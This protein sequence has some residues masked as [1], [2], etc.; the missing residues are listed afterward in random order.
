MVLGLKAPTAFLTSRHL[1]IHLVLCSIPLS[2][3]KCEQYIPLFFLAE[4]GTVLFVLTLLKSKTH[5]TSFKRPSYLIFLIAVILI[6]YEHQN[7]YFTC[8]LSKYLSVLEGHDFKALSNQIYYAFN[9][10]VLGIFAVFFNITLIYI[11]LNNRPQTAVTNTNL[12]LHETQVFN[13]FKDFKPKIK[14]ATTVK[15][16]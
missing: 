1:F 13:T 9:S 10:V 14:T 8:Q 6:V 3:L 2:F 7:V 16:F 11:I 4:A 12:H 15:F 5:S